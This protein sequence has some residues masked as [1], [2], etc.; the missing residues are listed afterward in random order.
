MCDFSLQSHQ[1]QTWIWINQELQAPL[2]RHFLKTFFSLK[3]FYSFVFRPS[4]VHFIYMVSV[5]NKNVKSGH[6]Y[7]IYFTE[8]QHLPHEQGLG[9]E[10]NTAF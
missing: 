10:K 4:Q 5:H 9:G 3:V 6:S 2:L 1:P 7:K 8:T